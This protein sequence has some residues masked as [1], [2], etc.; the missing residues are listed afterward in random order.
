M[1]AS[2]QLFRFIWLLSFRGEDYLEMDQPETR[3]SYD[4]HVCKRIG[5]KLAIII[6]NTPRIL[7]TKYRF[8]WSIGFRVDIFLEINQSETRIACG[9]HVC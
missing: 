3:I 5:T 8:I 1:G 9:G 2:Y 7:P 6:E 4:G